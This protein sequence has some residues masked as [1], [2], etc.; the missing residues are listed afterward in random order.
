MYIIKEKIFQDVL[1][2]SVEEAYSFF[3][4]IPS[5]RT[6]KTKHSLMVDGLY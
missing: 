5:L 1:N 2:M 4:A 3:E 6:E